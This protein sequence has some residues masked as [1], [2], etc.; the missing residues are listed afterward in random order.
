MRKNH[1]LL[2]QRPTGQSGSG[3]A[4]VATVFGTWRTRV[5]G[6]QESIQGG[7]AITT[8][9]FVSRIW[10][11]TDVRAEWR[12][13]DENGLAY[14]IGAYGDPNGERSELELTLSIIQ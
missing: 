4:T 1:R 12:V 9:V 14:Q 8:S 11:R 6:G 3:S 7:A 2:L 13:V 10:F 5:L